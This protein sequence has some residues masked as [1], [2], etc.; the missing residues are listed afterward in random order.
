MTDMITV[1]MAKAVAYAAIQRSSGR[2]Y[3]SPA[4]RSHAFMEI[5]NAKLIHALEKQDRALNRVSGTTKEPV[6]T[7]PYMDLVIEENKDESSE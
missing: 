2:N 6:D 3:P 4:M 7:K 5:F 1:E